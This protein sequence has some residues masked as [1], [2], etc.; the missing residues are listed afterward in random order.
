[1]LSK[2]ADYI[3]WMNRYLERAEN[4]ARFID[5]NFNQE[6]DLPPDI[7]QQWHPLLAATKDDTE[8]EKYYDEVT[9]NNVINFLCYDSRNPNSIYSSIQKAREN[10]RCVRENIT[11]EM[12]ENINSSYHLIKNSSNSK[13]RRS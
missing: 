10:A 12:W 4:Y 13:S 6:L 2:V 7:P 5:V 9:R 8:Y 11:V 1:M 3:Y